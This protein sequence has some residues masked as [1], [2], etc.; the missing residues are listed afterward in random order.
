MGRYPKT[1]MYDKQSRDE[2]TGVGPGTQ[3]RNSSTS[4]SPKVALKKE[5]KGKSFQEQLLMLKP[6]APTRSPAS[7]EAT[8]REGITGAPETLP[9]KAEMEDKLGT[10]FSHVKA[11]TNASARQASEAL[12]AVAFTYGSDV[13]F[14]DQQPSK[15]T[16]AHELT[17][18]VQQ[19]GGENTSMGKSA[20]SESALEREAEAVEQS[21][22]SGGMEQIA[23]GTSGLQVAMKGDEDGYSASVVEVERTDLSAPQLAEDTV[24]TMQAI[25][26]NAEAALENFET[27]VNSSSEEEAAPKDVGLIAIEHMGRVA[28]DTVKSAAFKLAPGGAIASESTQF[29]EGLFAA[30]EAEKKRSDAAGVSNALGDFIVGIRTNIAEFRSNLLAGKVETVDAVRTTYDQSTNQDMYLTYL[31]MI[32]DSIDNARQGTCSIASLFNSVA[33]DWI[34]ASQSNDG[35]GQGYVLIKLDKHWNLHSAYI[36]APRG[37][38]LGEAL[39]KANGGQVDLTTLACKRVIEWLFAFPPTGLGSLTVTLDRNNQAVGGIRPE[40]AMFSSQAEYEEYAG[41]FRRHFETDGIPNS[42]KITG[43]KTE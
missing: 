19:T 40:N 42:L 3:Y 13:A 25:L 8:A 30:I 33:S 29:V 34:N 16:V 23:R 10:D 43:E 2:S 26:V 38:R 36:H 22:S 7:T 39:V 31:T 14:R 18:V 11:H 35:S 5:L 1:A 15:G 24:N 37:F 27:V 41:R 17:H 6:D 21:P 4:R 32:R 12:G 20:Q 28:F 9:Y